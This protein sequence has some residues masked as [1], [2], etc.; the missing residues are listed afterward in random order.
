MIFVCVISTDKSAKHLATSFHC[1]G[2]ACVYN[3]MVYG[4]SE[5]FPAG[6]L[7]NSW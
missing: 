4:E 5:T 6:D 3:G 2:N 1:A 7:C